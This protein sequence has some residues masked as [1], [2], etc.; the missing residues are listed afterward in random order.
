MSINQKLTSDYEK[1][2]HQVKQL[3]DEKQRLL[4]QIKSLSLDITV[5]F[6][7]DIKQFEINEMSNQQK[8]QALKKEHNLHKDSFLQLAI[9]KNMTSAQTLEQFSQIAAKKENMIINLMN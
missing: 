3:I 2:N 1:N 4:N 6:Q 7:C 8:L 9:N 5:T